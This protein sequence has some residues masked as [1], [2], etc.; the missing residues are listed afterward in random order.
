[1]TVYELDR[2]EILARKEGLLGDAVRPTCRRVGVPV[3]LATAD[4]GEAL[5][6]AGFRAADG[7]TCWLV[8]GLNQYLPE[9]DVL[10][11]LDRISALSAPGSRLLT[12]FV[13]R[14]FLTAPEAHP[15]LRLMEGW[16]AP[17]HYGTDD[18][19]ALLAERGW[20]AEV[21]S[22][23][24]VGAAMGRPLPGGRELSGWLVEA[25]R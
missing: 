23:A 10:A 13:A 20:R 14:A 15:L 9:T 7:P 16:G 2:P 21:R 1:M 12:D 22:V 6:D 25:V 18:P 11:L 5:A 8:E 24:E 4:W 3:D 17:W 19:E